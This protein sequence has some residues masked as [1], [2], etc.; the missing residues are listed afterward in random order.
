VIP[1]ITNTVHGVNTST[2][3][4]T[5]STGSG[6]FVFTPSI[7]EDKLVDESGNEIQTSLF[8]TPQGRL[9]LNMRYFKTLSPELIK[10][11]DSYDMDIEIFFMWDGKLCSFIIPRG[12][13][14][15]KYAD[16]SGF[17]GLL[18]LE[19]LMKSQS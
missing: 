9:C 10:A 15:A 5:A 2:T 7:S 11:I 12:T 3:G 16:K 1:G 19:R 6:S 18:Y 14:I 17:I 4:G 13:K 8:I